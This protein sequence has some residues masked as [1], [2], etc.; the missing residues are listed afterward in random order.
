MNVTWLGHSCFLLEADG[1]RVVID[2]YTGVDGYPPLRVSAHA[3]YCSHD[4]YDHSYRR[5]V[6]LL[7]DKE[8]PF[9]VREIPS[10]HDDAE[11]KKRGNNTIHVFTADN[12]S[13]CH[14]G[15]LGHLLSA[16]QIASIG[17]VDV[18][19]IPVGG[20][21]TIGPAEAKKVICQIHPRCAVPMHYRHAPYGIANLGGVER[22]L[23]LFCSGSVTTLPGAEF[24]VIGDLPEILVPVWRET[25]D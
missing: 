8:N 11:G 15:D 19:L 13:V 24:S 23:E 6:T 5:G 21:Y 20:V 10:F 14:L 4:H 3:V 1:Y 16:E 12:V 17:K 7:P 22:F 18:L 25:G 2:P 9:S